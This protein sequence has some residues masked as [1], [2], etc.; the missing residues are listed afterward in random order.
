LDFVLDIPN[1]IDT[2][3][4]YVIFVRVVD[5]DEVYCN[6]EF[7]KIDL[8]RAED[9]VRIESFKIVE[10][11]KDDPVGPEDLVCGD[12]FSVEGRIKNF[13][14]SDQ[15][16]VVFS[17]KSSELEIFEKTEEFELEGF[18]DD[19]DVRKSFSFK[20]PGDA[21]KGVYEIEGVVSYGSD[22]VSMIVDLDLGKCREFSVSSSVIEPVGLNGVFSESAREDENE[23]GFVVLIGGLILLVV[24]LVGFLFL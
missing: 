21:L 19:D 4:D 12:S 3:N 10:S 17:V 1:D 13:G 16:D 2:E 11:S 23:L 18:G 5:G 7:V 8:E 15:D 24:V 22:E 20:I 14:S 6:E 9:D